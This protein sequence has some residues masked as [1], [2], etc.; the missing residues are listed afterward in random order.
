MCDPESL[1]RRIHDG[2]KPRIATF[3]PCNISTEL[4]KCLR[5]SVVPFLRNSRVDD[6]M[7]R[8]VLFDGPSCLNNGMHDLLSIP[9]VSQDWLSWCKTGTGDTCCKTRGNR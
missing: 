9:S 3:P 5:C 2:H 7:S 8:L 6:D 1:V 4:P